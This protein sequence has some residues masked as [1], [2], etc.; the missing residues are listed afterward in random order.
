MGSFIVD[1]IVPDDFK[2]IWFSETE[3]IRYRVL[4]GGRETGKSYNFIGIEIVAKIFDDERRNIMVLRQN[5]VDNRTSTFR[6]ITRILYL[7]N[8][9]PLFKVNKS[10]LTITRKATGQVI[11][12]GGMNDVQKIASTTVEHGYWTDIYIEE[13]SQL[14]S[15]ED[16]IIVDGSLRLP[17]DVED[18]TCQIT[19]CMNAWDVGHWTYEIFFKDNM[20]DNI[21]ELENKHYQF[22]MDPDFNIGYGFGLALHTS[23]YYCNPYRSK[24]KDKSMEILKNKMYDRYLVEGLGCWGA[25]A[26]RTYNHWSDALITKEHKYYNKVWNAMSVGIDFG[27]SNGQG[28][29]KYSKENAKRLGSANTMQLIGISSNW[30]EIHSVDEY[31][32]SNEGRSDSER[33]TSYQIQ[34]EMI[35]TLMLWTNKYQIQG[36]LCCYVD[37]ADSGGFIDGLRLEARRQGADNLKFIP[38]SKIPIVSRVYFENIMMAYESY[39]VSEGCSNLIREIKNARKAEDGRVREDFDDH[40]INA[41]EYAWIPLKNR[42]IRWKSFK[43]P[44]ETNKINNIGGEIYEF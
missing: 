34:A 8:L 30:G 6:Q 9:M 24:M 5:D 15:F 27:M 10:D 21:E 36:I 41:F 25:L 19:F 12:F 26:D 14:K 35:Q 22:F 42:L 1:E 29:I 38:A 44:Y 2:D 11:M 28:K 31:F 20:Q 43:D 40:A 39:K 13:A 17:A 16:F 33:K 4:K 18:L 32:D 37:S 3:D 7:Y 23:S